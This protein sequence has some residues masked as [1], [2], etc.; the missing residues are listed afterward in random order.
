VWGTSVISDGKLVFSDSDGNIYGASAENGEPLWQTQISGEVVGG[1]SLIGDGFVVATKEGNVQAFDFDG[2]TKWQASL[3]G[4]IYQAPVANSD[5][6]VAGM[7]NGDEL[8]YGFNLTGVQ[9][10]STTPEK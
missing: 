5:F 8:V 9:L 6:L 3:D 10:W 4:E 2:V 7:I 1:V